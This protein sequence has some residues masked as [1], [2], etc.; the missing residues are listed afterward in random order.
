MS[1]KSRA[2]EKPLKLT[3]STFVV[4]AKNQLAFNAAQAVISQPKSPFNPLFLHGGY[5][6]GKT[7]LLQGIC[8]EIHQN[9][10]NCN[11]I[12]LSAEDF[13]NHYVVAL[14]TR[15]LDAFRNR[16]RYPFVYCF[17]FTP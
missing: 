9:R 10:G 12:Y 16:F 1:P 14:K 15:K 8:N 13:A 3:L 7:H 4:G 6:V 5:G 11:W 17:N 2:T